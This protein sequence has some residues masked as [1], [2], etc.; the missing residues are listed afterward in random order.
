MTKP[1]VDYPAALALRGWPMAVSLVDLACGTVATAI[2]ST[3]SFLT[4]KA[5][6]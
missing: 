1:F 6:S 4:V 2:A 3:A 5:M